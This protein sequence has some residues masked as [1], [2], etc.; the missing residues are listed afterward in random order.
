MTILV[1]PHMLIAPLGQAQRARIRKATGTR[2]LVFGDDPVERLRAAAQARIIFGDI[3]SDVLDAATNLRWVQTVGAGVDRIVGLLQ[4]RPD[5]RVVSAKGGIVGPALAE[6]AFALLL[7][8]T[9]GVAAALRQPGFDHRPGIRS[10]QWELTERTILIVGLG[11]AGRAVAQRARGFEFAQVLAIDAEEIGHD[12]LVDVLVPPEQLDDLLPR[13]DVVVLTVPLT[14]ETHHLLDRRRLGLM[15]EGS[16]L[17][18]VSRGPLVDEV[19]L[20]NALAEGRLGGAGLDVLEDEPFDDADPLWRMPN[21]VL[22][23]HI[24]GGSPRRADRVVNQFCDNLQRDAMG[25]PLQ[26]EFS[27]TKGY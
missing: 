21:V 17:V 15:K 11:G 14:P 24:A 25:L 1:V 12:G 10:G 26:G 16:L 4:Q 5:V 3:Q 19:A 20:R 2:D 8:L 23:P 6:H 27:P 22:T 13:A 18:N 7:A 9:R